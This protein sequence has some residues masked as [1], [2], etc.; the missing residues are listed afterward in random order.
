MAQEVAGRGI[1]S[2]AAEGANG[3]Q[4]P[5]TQSMAVLQA[6]PA[7]ARTVTAAPGPPARRRWA[8]ISDDDASPMLWPMRSPMQRTLRSHSSTPYVGPN[9]N[10]GA[11]AALVMAAAAAAA[12]RQ[13]A[14]NS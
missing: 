13:F 10:P 7:T 9:A 4:P 2:A 3:L 14:A 5:T 11:G 8:S 6:S 1:S 12:Q